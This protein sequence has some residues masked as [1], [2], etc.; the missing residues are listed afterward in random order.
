[1]T[2]HV[3]TEQ[4]LECAKCDVPEQGRGQLEPPVRVTR[5]VLPSPIELAIVACPPPRR[6]YVRSLR[7]LDS[8]RQ[9]D[10]SHGATQQQGDRHWGH[11]LRAGW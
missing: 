4:A 1:M 5:H 8:K 3:A 2:S 11:D 6:P 7:A 9:K 10:N